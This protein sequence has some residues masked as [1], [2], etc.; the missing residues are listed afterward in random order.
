MDIFAF[1]VFVGKVF[2]DTFWLVLLF[3]E[4]GDVDAQLLP[5]TL[6]R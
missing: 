3:V 5:D 6:V 1:V 4:N 2:L